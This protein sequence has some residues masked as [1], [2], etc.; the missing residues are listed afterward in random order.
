MFSGFVA[1]ANVIYFDLTICH[2]NSLTAGQLGA[3]LENPDEAFQ[4]RISVEQGIK[5]DK[6]GSVRFLSHLSLMT[7]WTRI[8]AYKM[9]C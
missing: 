1:T 2:A 3:R 6:L 7:D 5:I 9:A 4:D 8:A